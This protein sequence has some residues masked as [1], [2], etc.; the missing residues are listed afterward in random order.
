MPKKT[1]KYKVYKSEIYIGVENIVRGASQIKMQTTFDFF[2]KNKKHHVFSLQ[3]IDNITDKTK[4]V[5]I[6]VLDKEYFIVSHDE[7][8]YAK[9]LELATKYRN[10]N[11]TDG[12]QT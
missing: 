12:E 3:F 2:E 5:T 7:Y 6:Y 10:I 8:Y 4:K 11:I 1:L 9:L